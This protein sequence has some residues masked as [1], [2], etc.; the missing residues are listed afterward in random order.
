MKKLISTVCAV[1]MTLSAF[2]GIYA[3]AESAEVYETI[4][5]DNFDN[6][7]ESVTDEGAVA[8]SQIAAVDGALQFGNSYETF[9]INFDDNKAYSSSDENTFKFTFDAKVT[10]LN[11]LGI[12]LGDKNRNNGAYWNFSVITPDA[13]ITNEAKGNLAMG[14]A[15]E[16][17][18]KLYALKDT[19]SEMKAAEADTWYSVEA[20]LEMPS[21]TMTTKAWLKSDPSV[22][23]TRTITAPAYGSY[24]VGG[25]QGTEISAIRLFSR[26]DAYIDNVKVERLKEQSEGSKQLYWADFDTEGT[27]PQ[28]QVNSGASVSIETKDSNKYLKFGGSWSRYYQ[29]FASGQSVNVAG[30]CNI[31]TSLDVK[32]EAQNM[33]GVGLGDATEGNGSFWIIGYTQ[34]G[35]VVIG[36]V[37]NNETGKITKLTDKAGNYPTIDPKKWYHVESKVEFPSKKMTTSLYERDAQDATAYSASA[38]A[39]ASGNYIV[40]GSKASSISGLRYITRVGMSIDNVSVEKTIPPFKATGASFNGTGIDITFSDAVSSVSGITLNG[41]DIGG[42]LSDDGLTYTLSASNLKTG[43][44]TVVVPAGIQ[45]VSGSSTE[46]EAVFVLDIKDQDTMGYHPFTDGLDNGAA[47][48]AFGVGSNHASIEQD[49]DGNYYMKAT[50]GTAAASGD[51]GDYRYWQYF[52]PAGDGINTYWN[53]QSAYK[54]ISI[55]FDIRTKAAMT[56]TD[57]IYFSARHQY[58]NGLQ[59]FG[60]D[61]ETVAMGEPEADR[62][63]KEITNLTPNQWYHYTYILDVNNKK[64]KAVLSDGTNEY[65]VDW[66]ALSG[67]GQGYW[68]DNLSTPFEVMA[69]QLPGGEID[70]DNIM[71]KKYYP[72]PTVNAD[73]IVIK[74]DDD[75]QADWGK[76]SA[77]TNKIEIDFSAPMNEATVNN[78]SIYVT[79]K[80]DTAKIDATGAFVSGKYVLTLNEALSENTE[81]E[82]HITTDVQNIK[83]E[84]FGTEAYTAGFKTV[85]GE[86]N[87]KLNS[88]KAADGT[89]IDTLSALKLLGGQKVKINIDYTNTLQSERE[90]NIIVAHFAG[91]EVQ[92]AGAE[93]IN[94]KHDAA[95]SKVNED[96]EYT[97]PTNMDNI[98]TTKVFCWGDFE[99]I[100]PLA[101]PIELK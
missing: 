56:A 17:A 5:E 54:F 35:G 40:G 68:K 3:H 94:V 15:W 2:S 98:T 50:K 60:M 90:Y 52:N 81:Y 77:L 32:F 93:I 23:Y 49:T 29:T 63:F 26:G 67:D 36:S 19:N 70:L 1:A 12:G 24:Q 99:T 53:E 72:A 21:K 69:F 16:D 42:T 85:N 44:Y 11:R 83:G 84:T 82:L 13:N 38:T 97:V 41:E 71:F 91:D 46:E 65:K 31:E 64:A 20:Y 86:L 61:S 6:G 25:S 87:V 80:G 66:K 58:Q 51:P 57:R 45:S 100:T 33:T 9:H 14:S 10:K 88:V 47:L 92:L 30:T 59:I 22:V 18:N 73:S 101:S 55:E 27:T 7:I 75:I 4:F 74:S 8:G 96:I 76:V 39:P 48:N 28:I 43:T 78:N 79:A 37:E 95:I 89:P 34:K 62:A